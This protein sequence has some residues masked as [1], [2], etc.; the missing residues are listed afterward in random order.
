MGA[1]A[2]AAGVTASLLAGCGAKNAIQAVTGSG[3]RLREADR[4]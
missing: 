1:A 2:G 3:Q 4:R